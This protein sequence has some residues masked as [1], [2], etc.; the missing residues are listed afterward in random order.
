L[1]PDL[2]IQAGRTLKT[3]RG[4]R[5]TRDV[6]SQAGVPEKRLR[7][8]ERGY[9]TTRDG[10]R[11]PVQASVNDYRNVAL[12]V[13]VDEHELLTQLGIDT[14]QT[15]PTMTV[16][17]P[18]TFGGYLKHRRTKE[19]SGISLRAIADGSGLS[20]AM[21]GQYENNRSLPSEKNLPKVAKAYRIRVEDLRAL[22]DNA[23]RTNV[24]LV[25]PAKFG[26]LTPESFRALLA[27]ADVLLSLQERARSQD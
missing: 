17:T 26:T 27:H 7:D 14:P 16:H 9:T 13:G 19:L 3:A 20:Y 12:A 2:L 24:E 5:T 8:M 1:N 23:L 18:D 11:K 6:A 25:L 22:W 4:R 15:G 21:L 10:Y